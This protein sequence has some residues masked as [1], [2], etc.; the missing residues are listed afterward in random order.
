MTLSADLYFSF[1][2]PYSYIAAP[3]YEALTREHDL[4]IQVRPV[5]PAAI[6][7]PDFFE[8]QNPLWLPYVLRDVRRV[9]AFN[10]MTIAMPRP[11]P[12]V[13]DMATRAIAADQP[14]IRRI[15]HL[16]VAAAR[17]GP[18]PSLRFARVVSH[19]LWGEN[20]ENWHLDENLGPILARA[21]LSLPELQ[22]EIDAD[23]AGFDAEIEA[24]QQ[25]QAEAGHWGVPCLVFDGEPFFGQDRIE[26]ALWTMKR[27]GLR[28]RP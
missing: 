15:T 5:W 24:N 14:Y 27:A 6:R 10:G 26:L 11:D 4:S 28:P 20:V 9:A 1:R 18:D 16:G 25:A 2:S 8:K 19:A 17:R 23:E 12:I 21:D 3:R 7:F 22:A 13:Q